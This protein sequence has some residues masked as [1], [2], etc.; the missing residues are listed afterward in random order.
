MTSEP[1]FTQRDLDHAVASERAKAVAWLDEKM[2]GDIR[3]TRYG[4]AVGARHYREGELARAIESGAHNR[5]PDQQDRQ[6]GK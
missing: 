2:P 4:V 1:T 3:V 5:I 6:V